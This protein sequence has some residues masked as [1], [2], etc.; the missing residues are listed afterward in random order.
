MSPLKLKA[1]YQYRQVQ[2]LS[3]GGAGRW[4]RMFKMIYSVGRTNTE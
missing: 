2:A 4:K 1:Q 3:G